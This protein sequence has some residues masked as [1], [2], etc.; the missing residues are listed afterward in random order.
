MDQG[1]VIA[2]YSRPAALSGR[3]DV[4]GVYIQGAS[5]APRFQEGE[6]VFVDPKRPPQIGDDVLVFLR[7][8]EDGSERITACLIKRL[9]R[10]TAQH[11]ELEQ[12]NPLTTF[13]IDRA[14]ISKVHR[15]IPWGELMA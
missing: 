15:V 2:Y 5:M 3:R 9:V 10:R 1:E 4:Y 8:E 14:Q 6:V 11:V 12:F 13:R 7:I